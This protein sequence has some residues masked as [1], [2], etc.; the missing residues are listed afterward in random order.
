MGV[1]GRKFVEFSLIIVPLQLPDDETECKGKNNC[2]PG[3]VST[4]S[5]GK[6]PTARVP[7][8]LCC[9][10]SVLCL[11]SCEGSSISLKSPCS[12]CLTPK[13]TEREAQIFLLGESRWA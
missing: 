8:S 7:S 13:R 11:P 6:K 10:T 2:V 5:N 1:W 12:H 3:Y 9:D 4:H